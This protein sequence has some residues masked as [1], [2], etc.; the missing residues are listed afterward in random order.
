MTVPE[1]PLQLYFKK[2]KIGDDPNAEERSEEWE[3]EGN[4]LKEFARL[5]EEVTGNEFLPWETEKKIQKKPM[6]FFP[7]DMVC[8]LFLLFRFRFGD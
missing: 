4:A 5:F 8:V 1:K 6:K 3:D 7:I 2:G